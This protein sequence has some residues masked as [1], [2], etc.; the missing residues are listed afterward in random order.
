MSLLD[1]DFEDRLADLKP[2]ELRSLLNTYRKRLS[3]NTSVRFLL[4]AFFWG[5]LL[6]ALAL[7][8][9]IFV[10]HKNLS[11]TFGLLAGF[12]FGILGAVW[13]HFRRYSNSRLRIALLTESLTDTDMLEIVK[14]DFRA[15]R[16]MKKIAFWS[17]LFVV[18]L[19]L[20]YWINQSFGF[21][22]VLATV[23]IFLLSNA[24]LELILKLQYR[25]KKKGV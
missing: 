1:K 19:I 22:F 8:A 2:D 16:Q 10:Y 6:L 7:F 23:S 11:A 5:L 25:L 15:N 20:L 24:G 12:L 4:S 3:A 13:L 9:Y 18:L 17:L 14:E 21:T